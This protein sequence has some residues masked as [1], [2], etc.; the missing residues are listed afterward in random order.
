E[1]PG[2]SG[3]H[4]KQ[5]GQLTRYRNKGELK[6]WNITPYL[7]KTYKD[8]SYTMNNVTVYD[9]TQ[10]GSAQAALTIR[11]IFEY[12]APVFFIVDKG[13][14]PL[15][16]VIGIIGN[17]ISTKIWLGRKMRKSNSSAVYLGTLAIVH[18]IFLFLHLFLDLHHAWSLD[19]INRPTSMCKI[20]NYFYMIP[21]YLAPLLVLG[22][23][24]ERYI[25]VCF[26]FK[27]E[28]FCTV[29]RAVKVVCG[30]TVFVLVIASP[31]AYVWVYDEIGDSCDIPKSVDPFNRVWRWLSEMLIFV[32][33]PVAVLAFNILVIREIQK[34]TTHGAVNTPN[35]ATGC[36][37]PA[38]T[39]TLLSV[40]F[41]L[42]FTLLPAT[43]VYSIESIMQPADDANHYMT[44]GEYGDDPAWSR[45]FIYLTVRKVVEEIC[46]S[47]F[48]CYV[49]I[50]YIT[51]PY[52]RRE[53]KS[54]LH[55]SECKNICSRGSQRPSEYTLKRIVDRSSH[56]SSDVRKGSM[57]CK[58]K[59]TAAAELKRQARQNP[60]HQHPWRCPTRPVPV[61][62][63]SSCEG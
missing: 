18:F 14:S 17:P 2:C 55:F 60:R 37:S 28:N 47:N 32:F 48:S 11:D 38:S 45:F 51:G 3:I 21:Q 16:Y 5:Q 39:I 22:F 57:L 59:R 15:F 7:A 4:H 58:S 36:G 9:M 19:T 63:L 49:F 53:V 34:L 40:S 52:F 42:I 54:M 43:I 13:V 46:L 44:A 35:Q 20:F 24:V 29:S 6:Q 33:V 31:Q 12:N 10:N 8:L 25:A 30:L 27:K 50:Y 61:P 62:H 23:T 41:Y 56:Q 26:P 1:Y